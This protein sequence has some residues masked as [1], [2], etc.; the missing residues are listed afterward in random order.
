DWPLGTDAR[1]G[2]Q[3][4]K[5][6]QECSPEAL[7][8]CKVT[9]FQGLHAA[10][11]NDVGR[12]RVLLS[13]T[14]QKREEHGADH[15]CP[16]VRQNEAVVPDKIVKLRGGSEPTHSEQANG[17]GQHYNLAKGETPGRS[18][19]IGRWFGGSVLVQMC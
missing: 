13:K 1:A 9:L 8:A 5:G 15:K 4:K 17:H 16:G 2:E 19:A 11:L 3:R 12:A 14:Y 7:V 18:L 6:G 10:A